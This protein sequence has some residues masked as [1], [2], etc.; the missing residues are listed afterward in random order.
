V[1]ILWN[2][3][4]NTFRINIHPQIIDKFLAKNNRYIFI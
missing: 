4:P 1:S 2:S 3:K